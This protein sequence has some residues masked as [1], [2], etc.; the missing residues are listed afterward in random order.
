[1]L[2]Q[3]RRQWANIKPTLFQCVVF[4]GIL[5]TESSGPTAG[6]AGKYGILIWT[7]WAQ[8][9]HLCPTWQDSR[10]TFSSKKSGVSASCAWVWI[11]LFHRYISL[12]ISKYTWCPVF[13]V[14]DCCLYCIKESIYIYMYSTC[15]S[16]CLSCT[17][18]R[19]HI[20]WLYVYTQSI[21]RMTAQHTH[22]IDS[23]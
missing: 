8:T 14:F 17:L 12:W 21:M 11:H 7:L 23:A 16:Q 5:L 6:E 18:V 4:A 9:S 19:F 13:M 1:M 22:H 15:A 2:G 10:L 20:M 3:R